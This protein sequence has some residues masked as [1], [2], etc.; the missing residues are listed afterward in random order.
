MNGMNGGTNLLRTPGT[1]LHRQVFL[2]LRDAITQGAYPPG[3]A[4]PKEESLVSSF[5]VA[6]ATVRRALA[7]LEYEGFVQRR[8]G[9]GTFVRED[10]QAGPRRPTLSY[11]DELREAAQSSSDV[12]VLTVE[13]AAPPPHVASLL[14]LDAG[15]DAVHAVR[16]RSAGE[17]PLMLTDAWVP[18]VY[19]RRITAAALRKRPMYQLL[20]DQG[21]QIGRVVQQI[22]AEAADPAK[23]ALL[24]CQ[25]SA[26][27]IRMTRLLHDRSGQPVQYLTAHMSPERS[28][29]L[30]DI[31][32]DAIDTLGAG[33]IAHEPSLLGAVRGAR[34]TP[35]R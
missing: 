4:L 26:P 15:E 13:K 24:K 17:L 35:P 6:R 1:L 9:R 30:M 19:G 29:V 2:V 34:R 18:R 7:D 21:V 33:H 22:S 8:H 31:P 20:V 23:A 5:G 3:T 10:L 25:V 11:V 28:C 32:G 16:L 27:L 12:E 14:E